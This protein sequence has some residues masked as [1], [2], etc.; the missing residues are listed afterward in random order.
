M[1]SVFKF[2]PTLGFHFQGW[3]FFLTDSL[4]F[5]GSVPRNSFAR[6]KVTRS[7]SLFVNIEIIKIHY[8]FFP[9]FPGAGGESRRRHS[10]TG[11]HWG[12]MVSGVVGMF[13]LFKMFEFSLKN[14]FVKNFT[15]MI[16]DGSTIVPPTCIKLFM[17]VRNLNAT[18]QSYRV[19]FKSWRYSV[20]VNQMNLILWLLFLIFFP[21][22]PASQALS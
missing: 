19:P 5:G 9:W 4:A 14:A 22:V 18:D 16:T 21:S 11:T 15:K 17:Q 12:G 13:K 1:L 3:P 8:V 20:V 2:S 7:P 6:D 10:S